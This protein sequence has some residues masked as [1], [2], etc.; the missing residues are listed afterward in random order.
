MVVPCHSL[1]LC[2]RDGGSLDSP[3]LVFS[4]QNKGLSVVGIAAGATLSPLAENELLC[5]AKSY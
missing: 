1:S 4:L 2:L 3:R 5:D